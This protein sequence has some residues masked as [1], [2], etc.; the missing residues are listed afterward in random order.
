M[1]TQQGSRPRQEDQLVLQGRLGNISPARV[2]WL[3]RN[4]AAKLVVKEQG[5]LSAGE[6]IL[7]IDRLEKVS[8]GMYD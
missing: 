1:G 5:P 3:Y 6:A 7:V 4:R 8:T 2:S